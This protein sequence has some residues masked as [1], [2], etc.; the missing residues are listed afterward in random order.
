HGAGLQWRRQPRPARVPRP[1]PVRHP[2]PSQRPCVLRLRS[3]PL[4]RGAIGAAGGARCLCRARSPLPPAAIGGVPMTNVLHDPTLVPGYAS[5]IDAR[6]LGRVLAG[7]YPGRTVS[8][9]ELV[10]V[11]NGTCSRV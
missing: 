8:S 5:E 10:E 9:V 1:R 6:W 4:H 11:T 3:A 7:R 2:A